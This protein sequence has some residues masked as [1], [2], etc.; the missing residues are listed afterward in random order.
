MGEPN[1]SGGGAVQGAAIGAT[2]GGGAGARVGALVGAAIGVGSYLWNQHDN[3]KLLTQRIRELEAEMKN[4][5]ELMDLNFDVNKKQALRNADNSDIQ[6]TMQEGF[7]SEDFNNNLDAL[8]LGQEADAFGWN[9]AAIQNESA[10]GD[11][12]SSMASSGVRGSSMNDA[13]E[14]QSA[15][16]SQQLQLQ[17]DTQRNGQ[18][19]Q[20]ASL[21]NNLANN[22]FNMQVSRLAYGL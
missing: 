8:R 17:E 12:L 22:T 4:R 19:I 14:M 16:N 11:A 13:V 7:V 6:T 21:L 2:F 5:L 3:D 1:K 20:L 18:S 10:E 9:A 15:L